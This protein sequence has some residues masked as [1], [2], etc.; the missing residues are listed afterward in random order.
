MKELSRDEREPIHM[1]GA[2]ADLHDRF[3][4]FNCNQVPQNQ[5]SPTANGTRYVFRVARVS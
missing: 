5:L 4:V 3:K 2:V 1:R